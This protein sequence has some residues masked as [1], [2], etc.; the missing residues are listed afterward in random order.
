MIIDKQV[1]DP[2]VY[3]EL[4]NH[5]KNKHAQKL[6][7]EHIKKMVTEANESINNPA[8]RMHPFMSQEQKMDILM[9]EKNDRRRLTV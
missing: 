2:L 6:S 8:N 4:Y 5:K 3:N 1:L 9:A 7:K